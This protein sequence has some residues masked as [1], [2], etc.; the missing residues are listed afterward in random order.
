MLSC[1]TPA[2]YHISHKMGSKKQYR[3][4]CGGTNMRYI[5]RDNDF[6]YLKCGTC[7]KISSYNRDGF[8][9]K[10]HRNCPNCNK[11]RIIWFYPIKIPKSIVSPPLLLMTTL[12]AIIIFIIC[13]SFFQEFYFWNKII[14]A[15]HP[16]AT[17]ILIS[18]LFSFVSLDIF[19][20][21]AQNVGNNGN[22]KSLKR[23]DG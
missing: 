8:E 11:G 6:L 15:L 14:T 2:V 10:E 21:P 12:S 9:K 16:L 19:K 7:K 20:K 4:F 23:F 17:S 13:F 3:L 1:K 22:G 5:G 18:T